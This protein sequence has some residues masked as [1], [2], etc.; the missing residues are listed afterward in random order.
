MIYEKFKLSQLKNESYN[1]FQDENSIL[2]YILLKKVTERLLGGL[3]TGI[4]TILGLLVVTYLSLKQ[5]KQKFGHKD[6]L[7][8]QKN[9]FK[10]LVFEIL[11]RTKKVLK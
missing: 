4:G 8:K 10:F 5:I 9:H 2:K 3:K 6:H 11:K 7:N 1:N